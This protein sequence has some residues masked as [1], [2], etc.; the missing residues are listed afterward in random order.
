MLALLAVAVL[1]TL[2]LAAMQPNVRLRLDSARKLDTAT[3]AVGRAAG[4]LE[5]VDRIVMEQLSPDAAPSVSDIR[6]E[7]LVIR[8]EAQQATKL[9]DEAMPGLTEE[10][11]RQAATVRSAA[12]AEL[13]M[14]NAAPTILA[15]STKAVRAKTFGDQAWRQVRLASRTETAAARDFE[16][17]KA[18]NAESA[19]VSAGV[20]KKRLGEARKLYSRAASAFPDAG[21]G[22]YVSYV[23][24]KS[25]GAVLLGDAA[26]QWLDGNRWSA[27]ETFQRYR[28][29]AKKS[30]AMLAALPAAPGNATGT[31]FR[32]VAGSSTDAYLKARKQLRGGGM[33]SG[34]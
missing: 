3:A 33:L 14:I 2:I 21:F 6:V 4:T 18:V 15:A 10:Q 9:V 23:N 31:A 25:K 13:A 17:H 12:A 26:S 20:E 22:R 27:R 34:P 19:F 28:K 32:R 29:S 16:K 8:T 1:A 5:A 7:R 30:S 24:A 11:R